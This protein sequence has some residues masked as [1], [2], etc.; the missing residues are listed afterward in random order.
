MEVDEFLDELGDLFSVDDREELKA[1][2]L[3]DLFDL[4][5]QAADY[6]V[7]I[8]PE[9]TGAYKDNISAHQEGDT[10]WV[11]FDDEAANIIEY[12]N[13]TTPEYAIR[14]KVEEHF[15]SQLS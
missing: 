8:S 9:E 12:G 10:V 6:A 5:E 4:A 2:I 15:N 1:Q 7:S 13:S 14:Q 11:G 3:A